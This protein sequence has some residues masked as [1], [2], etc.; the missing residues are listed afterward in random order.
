[1]KINNNN[2]NTILKPY[3]LVKVNGEVIYL[4]NDAEK[5]FKIKIGTEVS[6]LININ[7]IKKFSMYTD[8][9]KIF[10]TFHPVYKFAIVSV[11]GS[12]ISKT[13]KISFETNIGE[14]EIKLKKEKDV[15]FVANN[16]LLN[17][18]VSN[19]SLV[20]EVAHIKNLVESKGHFLN[21]YVKITEPVKLNLSKI[22][23]LI[24][25]AVAMMNETSPKRPV[26]LYIKR[27]MDNFIEIKIIVRVD[28]TIERYTEIGIE[29]EFPW[30]AIRIALINL[31][32][33]ENR[34]NYNMSLV[35]KSLKVIYKIREE[36]VLNTTMGSIGTVGLSL[37]ELYSLLSPR[38]DL[39]KLL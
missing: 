33:E 24:M 27:D 14:N 4:N 15:L 35:D 30:C 16:V 9:V 21:T 38:E 17:K 39:F 3:I 13:L 34:I 25:C 23:A 12:G 2:P 5:V 8:K 36:Q 19:I 7:E 29:E 32:C 20:D 26:D 37:E 18:K 10:E 31:I 6:R 28:T 11:S 1:M 22:Q